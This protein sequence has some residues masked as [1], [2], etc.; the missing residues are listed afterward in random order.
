MGLVWIYPNTA[1]SGNVEADTPVT[2]PEL[3]YSR[4]GEHWERPFPGEPFLPLGPTGSFDHRQIRTASSM[5]VLPDR[6]LLVYSGSPHAHV[7]SHAWDI[8]LATV[9]PDGLCSLNAGDTEGKLVTKPLSFA[10]GELIVNAN[11]RAGGYLRVA[12][13]DA[14]GKTLPGYAAD[15]CHEITGDSIRTVVKWTQHAKIPTSQTGGVRLR[16]ILKNAD[17]YSFGIASGQ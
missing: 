13:E 11:I 16:F 7:S 15:E 17:L 2:W 10:A 5:N 14:E 12:I 8:G 9:R 4:D 1:E 6:I 3:V